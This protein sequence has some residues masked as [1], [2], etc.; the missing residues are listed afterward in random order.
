MVEANVVVEPETGAGLVEAVDG[1]MRPRASD[2]GVHDHGPGFD[3]DHG[4]YA[5]IPVRTPRHDHDASGPADLLAAKSELR[6]RVWAALQDA[7]AARFPG[8]RGR[9]PNFTGAEAA[10]DRLRDTDAWRAAATVKA[11]PDAPQ[12]PVRQRALEDG[13]TVFMAVPRLAEEQPF[14]LL[15]PAELADPPR[16]ASSI[17]GAS[18]SA[19]TVDVDEL[20]PVD[21]VVAG[22]V[23]VSRDGARLGKGGGFSDLEFAIASEAGLIAPET[24]V[25]TTVHEVQLVDKGSIPTTDHDVHVDLI[26]TPD[27]VISCPK[28][29]RRARIDWGE[30]TDEKIDAIPLLGRL[31]AESG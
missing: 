23:A 7:G 2:V 11:N 18:R 4:S 22:S 6:E 30:L 28:R 31:R 20:E 3:V 14:F 13:K 9:I 25:V 5:A 10:A 29:P 8:A 17:K 12:W 27:R 26:V 21:L 15:D 1:E 24:V 16:K 19:H